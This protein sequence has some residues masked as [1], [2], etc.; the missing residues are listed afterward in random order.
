MV[1][2]E[3]KVSKSWRWKWHNFLSS[4][5]FYFDTLFQFLGPARRTLAVAGGAGHRHQS[6][7]IPAQIGGRQEEKGTIRQLASKPHEQAMLLPLHVISTQNGNCRHFTFKLFPGGA[8]GWL[9]SFHL[10]R[11]RFWFLFNSQIISFHNFF[12]SLELFKAKWKVKMMIVLVEIG[13]VGNQ[14]INPCLRCADPMPLVKYAQMPANAQQ[15]ALS[16]LCTFLYIPILCLHSCAQRVQFCFFRSV[17]FGQNRS[18]LISIH[19]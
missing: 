15:Y 8:C 4:P 9:S 16:P 6:I 18:H 1:G 5:L 7:I 3:Y 13:C 14:Q 2:Q 12:S 17:D 11:K 19:I 10:V